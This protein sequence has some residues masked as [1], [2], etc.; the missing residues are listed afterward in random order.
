MVPR[1]SFIEPCWESAASSCSNSRASTSSRK[2]LGAISRE[3][4]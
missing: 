4:Y 1:S 2:S 3:P